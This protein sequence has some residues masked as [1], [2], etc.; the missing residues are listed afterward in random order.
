[1]EGMKFLCTRRWQAA[2]D[3]CQRSLR[4]S[5]SRQET[6]QSSPGGRCAMQGTVRFF[7]PP[8]R[9]DRHHAATP[10]HHC[11][12]PWLPRPKRITNALA[13]VALPLVA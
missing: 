13:I 12:T 6:L 3:G 2:G 7:F 10:K 5:E 11:P 1:M 4:V 9:R 8:P